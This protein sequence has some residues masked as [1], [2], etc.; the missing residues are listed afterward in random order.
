MGKTDMICSVKPVLA[1]GF[2]VV[3]KEEFSKICA[4][5]TL[6]EMPG[7]FIRD[8]ANFSS[9]RTLYKGYYCKISVEKNF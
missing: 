9:E 4:K 7:I 8:K 1:E 2:C 5:Y 6:D 3:Q